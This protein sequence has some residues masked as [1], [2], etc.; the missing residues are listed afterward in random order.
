MRTKL[1]WSKRGSVTIG[2]PSQHTAHAK[3]FIVLIL[4]IG[5]L[6]VVKWENPREE[7]DILEFY[8][9]QARLARLGKAMGLHVA[10]M[11]FLMDTEGDNKRKNNATDMN[12]SAG[13]V[14]LNPNQSQ[15]LS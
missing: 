11:D 3:V 2:S 6:N 13:F 12:T 7:Y 9:G 10:A 15:D 14:F 8:A 1:L 5:H 4:L